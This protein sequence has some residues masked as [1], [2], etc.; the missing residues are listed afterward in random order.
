ML[1]L[2]AMIGLQTV[3]AM[4]II[5]I[6]VGGHLAT[7]E[8]ADSGEL[9]ETGL[10]GR[11]HMDSNKGMLFVFDKP[12]VQNFWMKNTFIPLSIGFFNQKL[13]LIDVQEMEP[14]VSEM[15]T[16]HRNYTS[17]GPAVL[18]LEMNA[19]WFRANHIQVN[20]AKLEVLKSP[21][22]HLLNEILKK[23]K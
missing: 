17:A 5:D 20:N 10:M 2:L 3:S 15:E 21:T 23:S 13:Q 19:N 14:V 16:P 18:A 4:E 11:H 6:R 22:S 1:G 8:V 7:V 12:E 9:R